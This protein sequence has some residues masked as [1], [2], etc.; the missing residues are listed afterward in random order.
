MYVLLFFFCRGVSFLCDLYRELKS[1]S[2]IGFIEK[3]L[4]V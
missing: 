1:V 3:L 2:A 4:A